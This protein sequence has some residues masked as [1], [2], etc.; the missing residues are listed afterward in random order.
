MCGV[1]PAG[2]GARISL[3]D[4][5]I[6][7]VVPQKGHPLGI[8][9]PRMACAAEV[10]YSPDRL[11]HPRRRVGPRGS[12]RFERVSW[13]EAYDQLVDGLRDLA[14]RYGPES[15]CTYTGRGNFELGLC[16]A[17]APAGPPESSA[18]AVLFPFGSPNA[19]GVGA[20]CYVAQ[21]MIGPFASFGA[22]RR[23]MAVEWERADLLL[24]WGANPATASPP[25]NL[26]RLTAARRRG[27]RVVVID[28]RRT[29][30]AHATGAR[31]IGVRP[32][33]DGALALGLMQVLVEEGLYDREFVQRWTHGFDD[34]HAYLRGFPTQEVERITGVPADDVRRL[35]RDIAR[36][37]GCAVQMYTGLEYCNGGVQAIRAVW[38]LMALAGHLDAPGGN[39]FR[40]K[41][42]ARLGRHVVEAPAGARPPVGRAEH[43]LYHAIR[44]EAHAA[45]LPRAILHGEPYPVR[46]MIVSGASIITSWPNPRLW[47]EAFASL[48]LLVVVDR[49]PTADA[50]YADLLL[51][52]TTLFE[53]LS[54]MVYDDRVLQLREPVIAPRGEARSDFDIFAGLAR[55]L[56][57]GHRF[58]ASQEVALG[59]ALEGT[60]ITL[61]QLRAAPMGLPLDLPAMR[62]H[63]YRTGELRADGQPG[64]ETPTGKFELSSS[65]L[66]QHGYGP[67]PVYSEPVEGPLSAPERRDRFPLV[68][69]TGA[70][71]RFMFRSQ[72]HNIPAM[73]RRQPSPVAWINPEDAAARRICDGDPVFVVSPRGRIPVSARVT[74][75][76]VSGV[77]EV[78]VG[79]GGPL[80]P[81]A[82]REANTNELTD[83]D[84]RDPLSGFPVLKAL[85]CDVEPRV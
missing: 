84:N 33:T 55:R 73:A 30:T 24:V 67:L 70:A 69:S 28:H 50:A 48:D 61:E 31:W 46:G 52:A 13:D 32:G 4:G 22:H 40:M 41:P 53:N 49:F 78:T 8:G 6:Q 14:R 21:G 2:C 29:R 72:H 79:G 56:G 23:Q 64:F 10:V 27:A 68:L 3:Q 44:N 77:V 9:C 66:K 81:K 65:W 34:L 45:E 57:Y 37:D 58:P 71:S 80:G 75:D 51:P 26:K 43:P 42:R 16:E 25:Q 12:G 39:V 74:P 17:F 60:G 59:Q 20:C 76:I 82:W 83:L 35:A 38:S 1:C 15:V 62:Y 11:L 47:R 85:L 63:K 19:T 18:N 36:A 7:R 5:R 54:Y